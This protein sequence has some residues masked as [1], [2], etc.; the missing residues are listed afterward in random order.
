MSERIETITLTMAQ[1]DDL[2]KAWKVKGAEHA[3]GFVFLGSFPL[4]IVGGF[5]FS[6]VSPFAVLEVCATYYCTLAFLAVF[7]VR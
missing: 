7:T 2:L 4:A 3:F 6:G 1:L 5:T